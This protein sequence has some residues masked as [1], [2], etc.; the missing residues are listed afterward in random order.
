[1]KFPFSKL[2]HYKLQPS[3]L[4]DFK[5]LENSPDNVYDGVCFYGNGR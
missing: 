4:H 3:P 5:I 2:Q 1:M